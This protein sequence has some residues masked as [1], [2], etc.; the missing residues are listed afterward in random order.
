MK[1]SVYKLL[2]IGTTREVVILMVVVNVA[3]HTSNAR[4]RLPNM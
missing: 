3:S 4:I 2:Q 1:S